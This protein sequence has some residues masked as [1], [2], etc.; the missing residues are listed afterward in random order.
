MR[1]LNWVL[2]VLVAASLVY[3]SSLRRETRKILMG[4][5]ARTDGLKQAP[6]FT[7]KRSNGDEVDIA[8]WRDEVIIVHFWASWCPPCLPELPEILSAAKKLPKDQ[9]GRAIRWLFISQDQTW[10]K[11]LSILPESHLP[12]NAVSVLDPEA[13]VSDLFGTYQFPETYLITRDGGI[14]M[15]WI[16]PQEWS[17]S[18]GNMAIGGIESLSRLNRVPTPASDP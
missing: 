5:Q 4:G 6:V 15:K 2:V 8:K 13:K 7:L 12:E 1:K 10:E 16:G 3:V 14:A 18:W 17:G 11:A 9:E